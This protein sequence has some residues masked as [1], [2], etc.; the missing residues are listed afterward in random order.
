MTANGKKN[1]LQPT[2]GAIWRLPY[3]EG[4]LVELPSGKVARLGPVN[5]E[6]L[7][8]ILGKLPDSGLVNVVAESLISGKEQNIDF[9]S[10]KDLEGIVELANAICQAMFIEPKIVDHPQAD[11]EI[12]IGH[13]HYLDKIEVLTR[14][15][16]GVQA[17]EPFHSSQSV[18]VVVMDGS[19][20]GQ[21]ETE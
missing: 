17:L 21:G 18:D 20:P 7:I 15:L 14:G 12:A 8:R 5:I 4:E 19:K 13:I 10:L 3:E 9:T 1:A 16:Q 6:I 2:S 11:N